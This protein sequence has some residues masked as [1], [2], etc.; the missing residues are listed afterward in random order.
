MFSNLISSKC[1]IVTIKDYKSR[2]GLSHDITQFY[3]MCFCFPFLLASSVHHCS[4]ELLPHGRQ[5]LGSS[6]TDAASSATASSEPLETP[7]FAH[8]RMSPAAPA[9]H[10]FS[11]HCDEPQSWRICALAFLHDVSVSDA[12]GPI[13]HGIRNRI[14][15]N[16][17]GKKGD[18][19]TIVAPQPSEHKCRNQGATGRP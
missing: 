19:A 15:R 7:T 8:G 5:R 14:G 3:N 1:S 16:G 2:L 17:L 13:R 6:A 11:N 9:A 10:S 4:D 12:C 18:H